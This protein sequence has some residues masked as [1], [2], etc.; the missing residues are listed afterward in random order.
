[1]AVPER[2]S[3]F[4]AG[5]NPHQ[6]P[7]FSLGIEE[8]YM[9]LDPNDYSLRSHVQ[10]D[11][12]GKG[13]HLL[14]EII[15]P[16]MHGSMIEI[17]TNVCAN[18]AE[19][20]ED[21]TNI[22]SI[23]WHLARENNLAVGAAS[24][25]PWSRW[26]DQEIFPDERYHTIVEDHQILARSLLVFGMHIH[27]GVENRETQIKIMNEIRYFLPYLLALTA[28][29]PFWE[30]EGTGLA[31][32]RSKIFER[33]PRT[34]LPDFFASYS[35][36]QNYVNLLIQTGCID[37][38]K[39]IWWDVRPHPDFPTLE[40]RICDVPMT[41]DETIAIAALVQAIVAKLF[42]LYEQNLSFRVYR[43]SLMM[44]NK[45]RAVRYGLDG[46]MID[47]G[48]QEQVGAPTLIEELLE[49]VDDVLDELGSR[50]EVEKVRDIVKNGN[51]AQRQLLAFARSNNIHDVGKYIADQ[52]TTNLHKDVAPFIG[53][54]MA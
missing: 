7:S 1:M 51:G 47:F 32:F 20:R 38:A 54:Y 53:K 39:K 34:N 8:E 27:I 30:G 43:R 10:L 6:R 12:L 19:A 48:K 15:K 9:I 49:F 16:E 21:L 45:W 33:F 26:Q 5:K 25:H 22:R 18:V 35:E 41:V 37:N 13:R 29:S 46:T 2:V 24:T 11:L 31:S 14:K 4:I 17:G 23:V 50:S 40:V 36:Y 42:S 44:E 3:D 28:N 52:F